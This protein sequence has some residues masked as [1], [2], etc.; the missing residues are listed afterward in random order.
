MI[1][2]IASLNSTKSITNSIKKL[3]NKPLPNIN[4]GDIFDRKIEYIND[5]IIHKKI[6]FLKYVD[7]KA[8][9]YKQKVSDELD[10]YML[11][12]DGKTI[13]GD[14]D[15]KIEDDN[16]LVSNLE[17]YARKKYKGIGSKLIQIAVEKSAEHCRNKYITL[18]EQKLHIFQKSPVK[19]Y[20]KLGFQTIQG[21]SQQSISTYGS[22]MVLRPTQYPMW[23][24][25][26]AHSPV[27]M[28]ASA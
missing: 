17:S 26:I 5:V 1:K 22:Q 3:V 14:I 25:R 24:D 9:I 13:L 12:I 16:I 18:N 11:T 6:N 28:H 27:L 23:I 21:Q 8:Q 4:Q 2:I 7:Q 19:F 10:R 15:L 20:E